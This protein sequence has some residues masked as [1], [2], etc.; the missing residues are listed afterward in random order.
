[1]CRLHRRLQRCRRRR[2]LRA[3]FSFHLAS[4]DLPAVCSS[5]R[6]RPGSRS[7]GLRLSRYGDL[8]RLPRASVLLPEDGSL[9]L[10]CPRESNPRRRAPRMTRLPG[11]RPSRCAGGLRGF[12]TGHP[13]PVEKLAAS[14][15]PP[16]GLSSTRPPRHT[17]TPR[18]KSHT[19]SRTTPGATGP[20]RSFVGAHLCATNRRSGTS[21]RRGRA[22]VRSYKGSRWPVDGGSILPVGS[23]VGAHPVRDKPTE[24]YT[25]AWLS[26]TGCAPTDRRARQGAAAKVDAR[27]KSGTR[28]SVPWRTPIAP[29]TQ[30]DPPPELSRHPS[31]RYPPPHASPFAPPPPPLPHLAG[32]GDVRVA[33]AV[34]RGLGDAAA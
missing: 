17:G 6:R 31:H 34:Q 22:Q 32:A 29:Q 33:G 10:A 16:F 14:M 1:L 8:A 5:S 11:L 27:Q 4:R 28:Y 2:P 26:R 20:G 30:Q 21:E 24:R 7:D 12:S 15:R 25:P 19:K 18:A 23:S 3:S 9:S 13:C